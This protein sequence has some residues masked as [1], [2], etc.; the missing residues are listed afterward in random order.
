MGKHRVRLTYGWL[1]CVAVPTQPLSQSPACRSLQKRQEDQTPPR[2]F[3]PFR[4]TLNKFN[5]SLNLLVLMYINFQ[6]KNSYLKF[7]SFSCQFHSW[8]HFFQK[9]F[10]KIPVNTSGR[11]TFRKNRQA[12]SNTVDPS[13][14][15]R[16]WGLHTSTSN[17]WPFFQISP[18]PYVT[19]LCCLTTENCFRCQL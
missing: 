7:S 15:I 11:H 9:T 17:A 3:L 6:H 10:R 12:G 4:S 8:K 1:G 13:N 19:H 14:N 16:M 18:I 2:N 5:Y